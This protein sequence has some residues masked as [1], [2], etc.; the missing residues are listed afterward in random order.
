MCSGAGKSKYSQAVCLYARR[1]LCYT[2]A[3]ILT[4]CF[5]LQ[6]PSGAHRSREGRRHDFYRRYA[7]V[8][9]PGDISAIQ[10]RQFAPIFGSVYDTYFARSRYGCTDCLGSCDY[11]ICEPC[12]ERYSIQVAVPEQ[13]AVAAEEPGQK[14]LS[15]PPQAG[16]GAPPPP[17]PVSAAAP[18]PTAKK[19]ASLK[20]QLARRAGGPDQAKAGE[21]SS[22]AADPA[23]GLSGAAA[24]SQIMGADGELPEPKT[25]G[26]MLEN[27]FTA[28]GPKR[29]VGRREPG[30]DFVWQTYSDVLTSAQALRT[31]L[32]VLLGAQAQAA[33]L[34]RT[35]G[36]CGTNCLEW[37]IAD[38]ACLTSTAASASAGAESVAARLIS[39][40]LH[41]KLGS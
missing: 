31:R 7:A 6:R 36:I 26:Q 23:G 29:C 33:P 22:I 11:I 19:G 16:S 8:P 18:P 4:D 2:G 3:R 10:L 20:E 32:Q 21:E 5:S 40:P 1:C 39:V 30:S 27:I 37:Y 35:V 13:P 14:Q 17:P 25:T 41:Y 24:R 34:V 12:F 38:F 15:G 28:F 9:S